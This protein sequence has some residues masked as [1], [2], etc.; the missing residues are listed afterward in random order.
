M[1]KQLALDL[2]IFRTDK[3]KH[4]LGKREKKKQT[5]KTRYEAVETAMLLH[6]DDW[7]RSN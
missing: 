5:N 6:K 3:K 7:I 1:A 2:S 4:I